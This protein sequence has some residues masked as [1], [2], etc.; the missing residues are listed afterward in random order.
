MED[1]IPK[2]GQFPLQLLLANY[3]FILSSILRKP[4]NF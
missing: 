2:E 1:P 3:G 4:L